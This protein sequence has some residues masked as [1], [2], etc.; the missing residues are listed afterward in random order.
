MIQC[1]KQTI[2]LRFNEM[3][4][5]TLLLHVGIFSFRCCGNE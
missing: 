4:T 2:Y 1:E 3:K 5:E